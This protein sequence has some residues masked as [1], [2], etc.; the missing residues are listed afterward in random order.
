MVNETNKQ[1][2]MT[3]DRET[4]LDNVTPLPNRRF[5]YNYTLLNVTSKN[6]DPKE[7][8]ENLKKDLQP[9]VC[10][11]PDLKIYFENKVTIEYS[12]SGSDNIFITKF[13]ITPKDC[14]YP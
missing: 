4:R 7:I 1:L 12:Y 14:G 8:Y 2:P 11:T 5:T 3:V 10:S 9:R 6:I 13:V